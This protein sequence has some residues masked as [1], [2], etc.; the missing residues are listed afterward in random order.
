PWYIGYIT[1]GYFRAIFLWGIIMRGMYLPPDIQSYVETIQFIL[2]LFPLTLCL[3]SS[4]YYR[5]IQLRSRISI[6]ES[7]YHHAIR[8][9]TV[10]VLFGNAILFVIYWSFVNTASYKLAFIISPFGLTLAVFSLFL[11]RKSQRLKIEYFK[12][13]SIA[14]DYNNSTYEN[15][16]GFD[17]EQC[18]VTSRRAGIKDH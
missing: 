12:L 2:F 6:A 4:C 11:Y 15:T 5:Y 1:D 13:Q 7:H 17:N 18:I 3:C 14:N 9:F 10:Y 8:I 16:I